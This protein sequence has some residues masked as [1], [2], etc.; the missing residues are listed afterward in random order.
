MSLGVSPRRLLLAVALAFA[1]LGADPAVPAPVP[2][3]EDGKPRVPDP[4]TLAI[5]EA[6]AQAWKDNNLKPAERT[7]DAEF[8]RR[9]TLDLLGR[10][11]SPAEVRDFLADSRADKRLR[12]IDRLLQSHEY[13]SRWADVWADWLL[14]PDDD[15]ALR[16]PLTGWLRRQLSRDGSCK[17]LATEL[18]SA[19]G[20]LADNGA[21]AFTLAHL[22]AAIPDKRQSDEGQ[23]DMIPLTERVGQLFLAADLHCVQCHDHPFDPA[24]R[25]KNFWGMNGFFRQAERVGTKPGEFLLRDNRELNKPGTILYVRRNG[26]Q[27]AT[28][29][30]FLDGTRLLDGEKRSRREMLAVFVT[31]HPSF[32]RALINRFWAHFFGRDLTQTGEGD[33]FNETNP[34][35]HPE[36]MDRLARDFIEARYDPR[37]LIRWL[38]ASDAYQLRIAPT[39]AETAPFFP[40]MMAKRLGPRERL[41]AIL[42]ALR[43]DLTLTEAEREKVTA[44]WLAL[45]PRP[46][47]TCESH[48]QIGQLPVPDAEGLKFFL[49]SPQIQTALAHPQG[50]VARALGQK[51]PA[52]ILEELFLAVYSRPPT[53]AEAKRLLRELADAGPIE[54]SEAAW[55]DLFWVI[56]SSRA[57]V[58][59]Q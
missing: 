33:V 43:A 18:L 58:Y 4:T 6:L 53:P 41:N 40:S 16:K 27:V 1:L 34:I 51:K 57:F 17:D 37:K 10:I 32:S 50:T 26:I 54:I 5:N 11:P 42:T 22:G 13:A 52:A 24:L 14:S 38:C 20:K 36:L 7:T 2:G 21:V 8:L 49:T 35:V 28:P 3:Q 30:E 23:F 25:Q 56:L 9:L 45:V 12:L 39:S 55:Q 47:A 15:V 29:A 19:T 59:N 48:L 44:G 31:G 46:E